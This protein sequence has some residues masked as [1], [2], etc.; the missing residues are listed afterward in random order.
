MAG[1]SGRNVSSCDCA[2]LVLVLFPIELLL[3]PHVAPLIGS[4]A[5]VLSLKSF[6]E[7]ISFCHMA[8]MLKMGPGKGRIS[9]RQSIDCKSELCGVYKNLSSGDVVLL[10][11]SFCSLDTH[12]CVSQFCTFQLEQLVCFVKPFL[13]V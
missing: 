4:A 9:T 7:G 1:S 12:P 10:G 6:C 13:K 5:S 8:C 3:S 2:V 11:Y